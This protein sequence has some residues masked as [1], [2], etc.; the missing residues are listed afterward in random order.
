MVP[1]IQIV[2]VIVYRMSDGVAW[3]L[4]QAHARADQNVRVMERPPLFDRRM[5]FHLT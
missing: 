3:M 4:T 1:G 5:S 2:E